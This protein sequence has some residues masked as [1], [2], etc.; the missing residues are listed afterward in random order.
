MRLNSFS[1]RL[2][3]IFSILLSAA[4]VITGLV[5]SFVFYIRTE[6]DTELM[7]RN[8]A[9]RIVNEHIGYDGKA[10]VYKSGP[11]D[12]NLSSRLRDFD[13]SAV[14][15]D[16]SFNRIGTYGYYKNLTDSGKISEVAGNTLLR[17]ILSGKKPVYQDFWLSDNI[18]YDSYTLPLIFN[19]TPVGVLQVLRQNTIVTGL[20]DTGS[21]VLLMVL[22]LSVLISVFFVFVLTKR[23]FAP[24]NDLISYMETVT[25]VRIPPPVNPKTVKTDELKKLALAFNAMIER[26]RLAVEKQRAYAAHLSHEVKT[27]LTRAV[28]ALDVVLLKEEKNT[29]ISPMIRSVKEELL[30]LGDVTDSILAVTGNSNMEDSS[31]ARDL[32]L[33]KEIDAVFLRYQDELKKKKLIKEINCDKSLKIRMNREHLGIILSNLISNAVKYCPEEG[34]IIVTGERQGN[35]INLSVTNSGKG[36]KEEEKNLVFNRFFRGNNYKKETS[37][38]GLGLALIRDICTLNNLRIQLQSDDKSGTTFIISGIEVS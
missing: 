27:P 13:I 5:L 11:G 17:T 6:R 15:F 9:E 7:L 34:V 32:I 12:A 30:S 4:I 33:K 36:I 1:F 35:R 38:S 16:G 25:T 31:V 23:Y 37:G 19:N 18:L 29:E 28:S 26:I 3:V 20:I 14:I 2:S 10:L 22:P 24:L 21:D 8:Q